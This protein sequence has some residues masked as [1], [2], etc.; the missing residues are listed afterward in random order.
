M[1]ALFFQAVAVVICFVLA[2]FFNWLDES[3]NR[4]K[5]WMFIASLGSVFLGLF[6]LA[7]FFLKLINKMF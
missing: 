6:I 4:E 3:F 5:R 7:D 2:L 1:K